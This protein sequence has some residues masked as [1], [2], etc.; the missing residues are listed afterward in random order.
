MWLLVKCMKPTIFVADNNLNR[1][2]SFIYLGSERIMII[3][4]ETRKNTVALSVAS[5]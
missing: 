2:K 4:W 5:V 1:V 3:L